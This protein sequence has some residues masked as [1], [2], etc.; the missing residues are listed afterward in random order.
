MSAF[1]HMAE[2]RATEWLYQ[3]SAAGWSVSHSFSP[4][5]IG[6]ETRHRLIMEFNWGTG[7]HRLFVMAATLAECVTKAKAEMKVPVMP[8]RTTPRFDP[9]LLV[10]AE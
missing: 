3:Q 2:I 1:T 6:S 8:L 7:G 5:R 10:A 9:K 4:P